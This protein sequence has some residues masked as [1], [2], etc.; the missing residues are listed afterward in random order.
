M[1]TQAA[2]GATLILKGNFDLTNHIILHQISSL[3]I[4]LI[5]IFLL[6]YGMPPS[7]S[8]F[9]SYLCLKLVT[10]VSGLKPY[11]VVDWHSQLVVIIE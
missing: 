8:R 10:P 2:L 4:L 5:D 11:G 3:W 1:S 7:S 9:E 6:I